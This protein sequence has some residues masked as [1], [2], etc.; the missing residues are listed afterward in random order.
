M[1][2]D[3]YVIDW[4]FADDDLWDLMADLV[5]GRPVDMRYHAALKA[6]IET[7]DRDLLPVSGGLPPGQ[8]SAKVARARGNIMKVAAVF[9]ALALATIGSS[10]AQAQSCPIG[11][12]PSVDNFGNRICKRSSDGS[13]AST[14]VPRGQTC[15]IGAYPTV[16]SYGNKVCRSSNGGGDSYDTSKGCPTGSYRSVDS[17]GN[18]VCKPF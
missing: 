9:A 13:A 12:Y 1:T 3:D 16:D 8:P 5:A 7:R 11:S 14:E 2:D 6:E 17:Y 15:P 10:A 4:R 18:K